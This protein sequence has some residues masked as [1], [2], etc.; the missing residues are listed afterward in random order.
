M[1]WE[2]STVKKPD[3]HSADVRVEDG[4]PDPVAKSEERAGRVGAD[5]GKE[6]ELL[7]GQGDLAVVFGDDRGRAG[8]EAQGARGVSEVCPRDDDV[9]R[10]GAGEISGRRPAL[11]PL[12]PDRLNARDRS[13]LAHDLEDKGA[14]VGDVVPAHGQVAPVCGEPAG[15]VVEEG[16]RGVDRRFCEHSVSVWKAGHAGRP[17]R[18]NL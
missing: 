8:L 2:L 10:R 18:P 13:L 7:H 4:D 3:Q 1:G 17:V 5:A 11:H 6:G 16:L 14:P 15:Q 12:D 9:R